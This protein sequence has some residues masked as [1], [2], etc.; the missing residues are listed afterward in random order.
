M[1]DATLDSRGAF[2]PIIFSATD[3]S[4]MNEV[5][6]SKAVDDYMKKAR[7]DATRQQEFKVYRALESLVRGSPVFFF[8]S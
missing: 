5:L 6:E 1:L 7:M 8:K 4:W 2:R 3:D